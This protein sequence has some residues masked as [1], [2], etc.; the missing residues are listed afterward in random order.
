M[1]SSDEACAHRR[2]VLVIVTRT[3]GFAG[4]RREWRAQPSIE[5][6]PRWIA[7]IK[8]APWGAE[9]DESRGADRFTWRID[10]QYGPHERT[11]ELPEHAVQGPWQDLIEQVRGAAQTTTTTPHSNASTRG[12]VA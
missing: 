3:G 6:E 10:A 1:T 7:L 11:I 2:S 4:L 9:T 12:P 8:S 5:D